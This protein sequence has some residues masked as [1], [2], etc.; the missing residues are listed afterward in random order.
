MTALTPRPSAVPDRASGDALPFREEPRLAESVYR[1]V[2]ALR[3]DPRLGAE[4]LPP[5][6]YLAVAD[7]V[8]PGPTAERRVDGL[9]R[10]TEPRGRKEPQ[11]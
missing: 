6:V 1:V 2:T 3:A 11:P 7:S 8:V 5:D 4:A 10:R 9:S